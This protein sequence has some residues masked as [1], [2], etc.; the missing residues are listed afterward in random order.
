ME[1]IKKYVKTCGVLNLC[2]M[3]LTLFSSLYVFLIERSLVQRYIDTFEGTG[4]E[5]LGT[6]LGLAILLVFFIIAAV[7]MLAFALGEL[8]IGLLLLTESKKD[9]FRRTP[10]RTIVPGVVMML[11]SA[12]GFAFFCVF[13][14]D[15]AGISLI[16]RIFYAVGL[17][18]SVGCAI[19]S[20]VI[21]VLVRNEEAALR[22]EPLRVIGNE[23]FF[24]Q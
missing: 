19:A 16:S 22:D 15:A 24:Y 23:E 4:T 6:G 8:I 12:A 21:A 5:Q 1:K 17:L 14:F 10:V 7:I 3:G 13:S 2:I 18:A 11:L 20:I 9:E